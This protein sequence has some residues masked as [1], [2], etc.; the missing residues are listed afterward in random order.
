M[1]RTGVATAA[2]VDIETLTARLR[3]EVLA[4]NATLVSPGMIGA[5][6]RKI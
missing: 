4:R 5:W 2:K 3:E 1:E 6:T